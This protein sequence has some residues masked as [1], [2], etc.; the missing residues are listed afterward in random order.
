[1]R[2]AAGQTISR[3]VNSYSL[4]Y[5][6]GSLFRI[7]AMG[8]EQH[9]TYRLST[10]PHTNSTLFVY[11][12]Y[13]LLTGVTPVLTEQHHYEI[14]PVNPLRTMESIQYFTYGAA[15]HSRVTES[16]STASDGYEYTSRTKY[17]DDY[18]ITLANR[19]LTSTMLSRLVEKNVVTAV[20]QISLP[21]PV[22]STNF[23]IIGASLTG[24]S[25]FGTPAVMQLN[26]ASLDRT[27]PL[28]E[29]SF[30]HSYIDNTGATS[31]FIADAG[32]KVVQEFLDYS[33]TGQ[34]LSSRG[35]DLLKNGLHLDQ[36]RALPVFSIQGAEAKECVYSDFD[37]QTG[38]GF[39]RITLSVPDSPFTYDGGRNL[40]NSLKLQV[41]L[42][43][44]IEAPVVKA[45]SIYMLSYW[46][47][48]CPAAN[49]AIGDGTLT[50][51][52]YNA[53]TLLNTFNLNFDNTSDW[54]YYQTTIDVSTYPVNLRLRIQ[55]GV[56]NLC[57]ED[58]AFYPAEASFRTIQYDEK[59]QIRMVTDNKGVNSYFEYD[60]FGRMITLRDHNLKIREIT[61]YNNQ[62]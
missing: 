10:L 4:K 12:Q 61:T 50:A 43:Y 8:L 2:N 29:S 39:S 27:S 35:R 51:K 41:G 20:E 1:M 28:P 59:N 17:A 44:G 15:G 36:K 26:K 42:G 38:N 55:S 52:I 9:P 47:K 22:G 13:D 58:V 25:D 11:G 57:I 60:A 5:R 32:Y 6:N 56:N 14:D 7:K 62:N 37:C 19:D 31:V 34:L 21:N 48:V 24:F 33:T 18:V 45:S 16:R 53:A 49:S 30:T 40:G 46:A 54:K 3:T 23:Q